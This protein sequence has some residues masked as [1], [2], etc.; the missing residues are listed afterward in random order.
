MKLQEIYDALIADP[1]IKAQAAERIKF[2]EFPEAESLVNTHI[3]IDP[4][5]VPR[6]AEFADDMWLKESHLYQIDVWS[7]DNSITE[8]LAVHIQNL[9]WSLGFAQRGGVPEWD[10]DFNVFRDARRYTGTVYRD[11]FDTL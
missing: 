8:S 4:L 10:K 3:I 1:Y 9:M 5:D 7:K 11:D 6:P 2:Y